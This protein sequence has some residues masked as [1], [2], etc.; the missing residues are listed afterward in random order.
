MSERIVELN[1]VIFSYA[2]HRILDDISLTVC[3]GEKI[4]IVGESGCGKSTLL[5]LL[6]GL[7]PPEAGSVCVA[8]A[9]EPDAVSKAVSIVMQSPMLLPMTIR[10]NI[11]L[12]HECAEEKLRKVLELASLDKWIDAL[13]D[14]ADTYLGDRANEL[15]GG[16]AQRIA[17]ARAMCKDAEVLLL[18]E[19]TSALD[20]ETSLSV[21][22]ALKNAT[23]GKTVLHVT[24]AQ[25]QLENYDRVYRLQNGKLTEI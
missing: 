19:P 1:H 9:T 5:H 25:E 6:A 13:P 11:T 7:Y 12:G 20:K 8:G 21:L 14:G 17:I 4:G 24:H 2:E 15:S 3:K 10:E 23:A 16:Q 18:D 22:K